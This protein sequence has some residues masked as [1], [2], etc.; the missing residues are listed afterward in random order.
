MLRVSANIII[1]LR[2][3][4]LTA[5]RAQGAGGQN[6]NKVSSAI[7]LRFDIP[8]S[9]LSEFNKA[10]LLALGDSRISSQGVLILKAQRHRTQEMNRDD[11]MMRLRE[12]ILAAVKVSK[13]RFATK[14]SYSAKQKRMDSKSKR[15]S[16]KANRQSTSID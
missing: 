7:H 14:P 13:P 6:V 3:I 8:N 4:E 1:P 10:K 9:S 12:L 15:G 2:E 5:M 16:I 11:A